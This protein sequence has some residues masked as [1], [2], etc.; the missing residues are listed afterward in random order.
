[1]KKTPLY[2][3][4]C[5][6]CADFLVW[7]KKES[8]RAGAPRWTAYAE[9][10]GWDILLVAGDGTQIGVQAKLK[11]N[12]KVLAQSVPESW[13]SWHDRGPD[14]RAVLVPDSDSSYEAICGALGL[15]VIRPCRGDSRTSFSPGLGLEHWNGGWHYWSPRQRCEVP[16]FV[17]D[18]TA[19]ASA[20]VQLTKWKIAALRIV[21]TLEVRGFVTRA[22]FKEHRIDCRRWTGP[23]GWLVPAGLPGQFMR[24]PGLDFDRQHPTVYAQVLEG[25]RKALVAVDTPRQA[26]L[27]VEAS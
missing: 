5:D 26:S 10:A 2:A 8:E 16:E 3:L 22:D 21:A 1:M 7:V 23:G 27:P 9:T 6:L 25:V 4:E 24:G 12:L 18:V 14:Y 15:M 13:E 19:G 11:A 20:P 17:P